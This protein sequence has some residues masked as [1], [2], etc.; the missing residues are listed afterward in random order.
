AMLR[1]PRL[2][3]LGGTMKARPLLLAVFVAAL[4]SGS[5]CTNVDS[6]EDARL[7]YLGLDQALTRAVQLGFD[8]FNAASSANIPAQ[9]DDG[10][11]SGEM[12][13]SG[14]V[15]QGASANKGMRLD[16]ALTEY[17]DGPIDD[18]ETEDVTEELSIVY[19]TE[20]EA[21]LRL[22]MQLKN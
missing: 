18:P 16:V 11:E 7:A 4:F 1:T 14:Q 17:S 3:C 20:D 6:E 10:E 8:G 22:E 9:N 19:D 2:R 15:D 13:V 21:A 5:A 12:D